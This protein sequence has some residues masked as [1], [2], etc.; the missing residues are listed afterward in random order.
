MMI[1]EVTYLVENLNVK[2]YLGLPDG[3]QLTETDVQETVRQATGTPSYLPIRAVGVPL[4]TTSNTDTSSRIETSGK[5]VDTNQ[6]TTD[7]QPNDTQPKK[8]FSDESVRADFSLGGGRNISQESV[9]DA[10]EAFPAILYCRGGIG[11]VGMSRLEWISSFCNLGFVVFSPWYR[12]TLGTDGR[13][14]F[15]GADVADC[16]MGFRILRQLA[17]VRANDITLLGFSRGSINATLTAIAE[18]TASGLIFWGGVS[19]LAATYEERVDLRR[20]LRRVIGHTPR[21]LPGEYRARSPIRYADQVPCRTLVVHSTHDPQVAFHHGT[22]MYKAL[23]EAGVPVTWHG[24]QGYAHHFDP[25]IRQ[26]V[27]E[28]ILSWARH[29]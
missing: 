3:I 22:D 2:G 21:R 24:Y 28:R 25:L 8:K 29:N 7:T 18:P 6:V 10:S 26:A 12:G 13:D 1:Y 9:S 27:I 4:V 15:G 17:C 14:E 20:M 23:L 16:V 5:S 11:R 19:D